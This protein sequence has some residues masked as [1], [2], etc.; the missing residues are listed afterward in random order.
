MGTPGYREPSLGPGK[1][2]TPSRREMPDRARDAWW[3]G[4]PVLCVVGR[5]EIA[6]TMRSIC[7]GERSW[8]KAS[9]SKKGKMACEANVVRGPGFLEGA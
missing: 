5:G 1:T 4:M 6:P 8:D 3:C 7:L 2:G 9:P